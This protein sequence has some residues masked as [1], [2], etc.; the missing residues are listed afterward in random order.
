MVVERQ[1]P[2]RLLVSFILVDSN[3]KLYGGDKKFIKEA[4]NIID[5]L[6][7]QVFEDLNGFEG[8]VCFDSFRTAHW[9]VLFH[10]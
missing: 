6:L 5:T 2:L 4:V 7:K 1:H 8:K 3:D 10:L 9:T